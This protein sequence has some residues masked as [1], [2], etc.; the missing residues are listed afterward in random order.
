MNSTST[1]IAL[2]ADDE[3]GP[4]ALLVAALR[5]VWPQWH[6]V[7]AGNGVDAWDAYLEHQPRVTFLDVRMPGMTGIEVAQRIGGH[8]HVVFVCGTTDHALQTFQ[9]IG[10][11]HLIK[12]VDDARVAALATQLQPQLA[13]PPADLSDALDRLG[14]RVRKPAPLDIISGG[15][16]DDLQVLAADDVLYFETDA[17]LTRVVHTGGQM[18]IRTPIKELLGSLDATRFLQIHRSVIVN[19]GFVAGTERAVDGSLRLLLRDRPET[20]AVAPQF[21]GLFAGR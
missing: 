12:P 15:S 3:D 7:E 11:A 1:S 17:R 13:G 20:L 16:P 2:I 14:G 9:T 10:I 21:S 18:L 4:R 8:G 19:Q 6:F 5:A